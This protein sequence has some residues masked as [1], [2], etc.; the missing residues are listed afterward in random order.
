MAFLGDLLRR[1]KNELAVLL[2]PVG[3]P[4]AD[5]QVPKLTRKTLD[6]IAQWNLGDRR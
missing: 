5:A 6:Q 1:P 3:F 4:A 2:L